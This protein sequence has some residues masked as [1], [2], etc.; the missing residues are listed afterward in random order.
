MFHE[1]YFLRG[2][3]LRDAAA[4]KAESIRQTWKRRRP[5]ASV[6]RE[7]TA[8]FWTR[9]AEQARKTM[10]QAAAELAAGKPGKQ[11]PEAAKPVTYMTEAEAL[12]YAQQS[13]RR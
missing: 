12:A 11:A 9:T 10:A 8:E 5:Q 1:N 3:S 6:S 2:A 13:A 4:Q 7:S